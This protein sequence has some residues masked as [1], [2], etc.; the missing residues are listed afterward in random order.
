MPARQGKQKEKCV[1]RPASVILI[2][3]CCPL[4]FIFSHSTQLFALQNVWLPQIW[5]LVPLD[6]RAYDNNQTVNIQT[7]ALEN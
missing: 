3:Q 1:S 2:L 6:L 4:Q 5:K 7:F